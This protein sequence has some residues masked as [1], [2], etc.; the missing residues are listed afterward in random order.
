MLS[1]E[2]SARRSIF[3]RPQ[4]VSRERVMNKLPGIYYDLIDA[5]EAEKTRFA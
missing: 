3:E 2:K 5:L 1:A 4:T